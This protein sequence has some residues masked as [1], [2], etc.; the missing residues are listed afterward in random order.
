[1]ALPMPPIQGD[2]ASAILLAVGGMVHREIAIEDLLKR[3]VDL[4]C[5]VMDADRG[6]IYL[7]DRGK[8]E[9]F[10]KVAHLPELKE[11]RLR[12]G[13]G[14]AGHVARTGEVTNVPTTNTDG[15]FYNKIDQQTGYRTESVIAAPMRDRKGAVIGVVQL[16]NKSSGAFPKEDE[17][18]LM[19]LAE[20]AALAVESTTLYAD[21]ARAPAE[22]QKPLPIEGQFNL[23]VGESEELRSACKLTRRA[24]NSEATVLIRGESGT[25]KELFARAI[26]VNSPRQSGPF[27]KVD[28]A[29]LP[30]GLIENELFGHERGAY[31]GAEDRAEGKFDAAKGGTIFL[32][33]IGELPLAVQGKLLR[34]LQD[35]E[36]DRVGGTEPIKADVRVVA[37][38]NRDLEELVAQGSFR[39]DL[40]FRIK[41]VQIDLPAL[42]K[43]GEKDIRRL[44]LHF[45]TAAAKRHGRPLPNISEAALSRLARYPWPGNVRELENIIECAVVIT[46]GAHIMADDLTLP[47]RPLSLASL[48]EGSKLGAPIASAPAEPAVSSL[49]STPPPTA[50]VRTLDEV[51]REHILAMLE[52]AEGNR[53]TAARLLGIGRNTLTRK[54]KK[55]GL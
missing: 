3:L 53:T 14:L 25:G 55:Y 24:A 40:Y 38:T 50:L 45:A 39:G 47:D 46:E 51:E 48:Y 9:L 41:V 26:H 42:R 21:L 12:V 29:A 30:E 28:C 54:L 22:G 23:I 20:Q 27:I 44:A 6:T 10:S 1:M 11:I 18:T 2:E 34:V 19:K 7:V 31:T 37:A 4:I 5:E 32:D 43:R 17:D 13:Q 36:F 8:Q 16:L 49:P 33:E 15:R 35:R 52:R